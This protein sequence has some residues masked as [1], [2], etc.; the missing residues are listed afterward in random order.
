[1]RHP[2]SCH[3]M[4]SSLHGIARRDKAQDTIQG[5]A[6]KSLL[7][8]TRYACLCVRRTDRSEVQSLNSFLMSTAGMYAEPLQY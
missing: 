7:L 4:P 5:L 1:M 6:S 2:L 3:A 8:C